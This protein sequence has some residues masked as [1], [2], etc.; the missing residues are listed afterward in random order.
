MSTNRNTQSIPPLSDEIQQL[1]DEITWQIEPQPTEA[2]GA[3]T[4]FIRAIVTEHFT[5]APFVTCLGVECSDESAAPFHEVNQ[6]PPSRT[7]PRETLWSLF[8]SV[9]SCLL[10]LKRQRM[11]AE[12]ERSRANRRQP[13]H[14]EPEPNLDRYPPPLM[15]REA[16]QQLRK[17]S[18]A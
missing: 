14:N 16:P 1:I 7:V 17:P 3:D 15:I 8:R 6:A 11:T 13:L 2:V 12:M 4:R 9:I 5:P 10:N 18:K